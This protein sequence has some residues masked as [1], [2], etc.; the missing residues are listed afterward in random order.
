MLTLTI[1]CMLQAPAA[2]DT[3]TLADA[4]QRAYAAR[5]QIRAVAASMARARATLRVAGQLPNPMLEFQADQQAP[6]RKA[7]LTQPL[8][9]LVRRGADRGVARALA[10]RDAA[11]STQ[12]LATLVRDVRVS[13]FT[14][15]A[16]GARLTLVA[17]QAGLAD[18]L[19]AIAEQRLGAG[20]ISVLERDQAAQ[21]AGRL[22]L[23]R[24]T[25]RE[26]A[27]IASVLLS[28]AIGAS[29]PVVIPVVLPPL[30][31]AAPEPGAVPPPRV[32]MAQAEAE[33]ARERATVASRAALPV[34]SLITGLDWAGQAQGGRNLIV[35]ALMPVPLWQQNGGA[36]AEARA[37]RDVA[38]A[39]AGEVALEV[40]AQIAAT[41][42]RLTEAMYRAR[43]AEATLAPAAR[44]LR[45]GTVRLYDA[46]RVGLLPVL[47][48]LRAERD[49]Q[50][51]ALAA[52]LA[53]HVAAADLQAL[54]G[55][56]R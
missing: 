9:W 28:R 44:Q 1:L 3:L 26:D 36:R 21:E 56:D 22:A 49:V 20:D 32:R 31:D 7:V 17:E 10:A 25:A 23:L 34:P 53:A 12:Q 37:A 24:S 19:A 8:N 6:T 2:T 47:D 52:S 51:T 13:Y 27:A 33:A 15:V 48:A 18:T 54:L 35:G 40:N 45:A 43:T 39:V 11:D 42:I 5:P 38:A 16:A 41:R 14:A 4:L 46:G 50:L 30:P 29:D 55:D